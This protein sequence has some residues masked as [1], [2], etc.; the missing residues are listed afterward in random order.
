MKHNQIQDLPKISIENFENIFNVYKD[1]NGMYYYNLL[2]TIVFPENLPQ[3]LFEDYVVK[4]EDSWPRIS[5]ETLNNVN[6]WWVILLAN[7]INDPTSLPKPGTIIKIPIVE[8]V[9][10]I[11]MQ[12]RK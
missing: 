1:E 10:E 5:Y 8:V 12:M 9:R 4:Q 11:L 2:Q 7:K 3:N 6:L